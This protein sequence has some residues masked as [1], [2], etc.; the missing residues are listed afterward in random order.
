MFELGSNRQLNRSDQLFAHGRI[1]LH[2]LTKCQRA[3]CQSICTAAARSQL[4]FRLPNVVV[5]V[6]VAALRLLLRRNEILLHKNKKMA[7]YQKIMH[8]EKSKNEKNLAVVLV[9]VIIIIIIVHWDET[10]TEKS[11]F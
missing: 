5:F 10:K 4:V 2:F 7:I 9:V 11:T 3:E 6:A 1:H 8:N